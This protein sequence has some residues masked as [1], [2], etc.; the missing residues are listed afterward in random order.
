MS[1][2]VLVPL[3]CVLACASGDDVSVGALTT[4]TVPTAPQDD[5]ATTLAA[6]TTAAATTGDP[7]DATTTP[8]TTA[9]QT[10]STTTTATTDAG[11]TTTATTGPILDTGDATTTAPP[12]STTTDTGDDCGPCD[13]PP[14]PCYADPGACIAGECDYAPSP[15]GSDCDDGDECTEDDACN[16]AGSCVGVKIQCSAPNTTGGACQNGAC[17]GFDCVAPY[18]NCDGDWA[19]GCEVPTGVPNQCDS[20]GIT[21][22]GGCWTAYCGASDDAD[23]TNFGTYHC[24]DCANCHEPAQGQ[25]QWCN[26]T[27]GNWYP[28][29]QG[30]PCGVSKDLVCKA[31]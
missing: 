22:N 31:G 16:G 14:G 21:P 5:S 8:Q 1:P 17:T 10:S 18:D 28:Q 19:N 7:S 29:Q 20:G 24:I 6:T 2:R 15:D 11:T 13:A 30:G 3:L 4:A 26:H 23:A 27:S 12:P 9:P 25:W